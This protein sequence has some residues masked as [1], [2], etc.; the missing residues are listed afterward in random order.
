M[1]SQLNFIYKTAIFSPIVWY[2]LGKVTLK[3][4]RR[5]ISWMPTGTLL[6]LI[7]CVTKLEAG[8]VFLIVI[9]IIKSVWSPKQS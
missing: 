1:K 7:L 4:F 8:N 3:N 6:S 5:E 9:Y 2:F